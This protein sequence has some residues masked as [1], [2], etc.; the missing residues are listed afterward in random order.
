MIRPVRTVLVCSLIVTAVALLGLGCTDAPLEVSNIQVGRSLNPDKSVGSFT[1]LFKPHETVYVS[2]S[3]SNTGASVIS[4]RWTYQGRVVDEPA[5]RAS[6]TGAGATEFHLQ[7]AGGFPPGDYEVEV[8]V[9][10]KPA[11][12]RTFKVDSP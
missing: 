8:F 12:R 7:N 10:T 6:F 9:D 2:V 3:T 4:V 1:T 11:G 5:K